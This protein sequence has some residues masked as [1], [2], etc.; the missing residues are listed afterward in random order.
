MR[1]VDLKHAAEAQHPSSLSS[2][3]R[4]S[5][6]SVFSDVKWDFTTEIGDASLCVVD[7]TI[8]WEFKVADGRGSLDPVHG[9]MLLAL[10]Q[11][12]YTLLF[13]TKPR[14]C[15]SVVRMVARLKGFVSFL[16][17]GEHP[18]YR[19]QDVLESD[20][21]RYVDHL[22]LRHDGHGEVHPSTLARQLMTLNKLFDYQHYL[23]DH[24]RYRPTK[25][26][27]P[28][29]VAGCRNRPRVTTEAVPDP[30]LKALIDSA[31][32]YTQNLAPA[33][34]KCLREYMR[35]AQS[36]GVNSIRH[37]NTRAWHIKRFFSGREDF[38]SSAELNS[39]LISLRTACFIVIAFS[40]GMRLSEI[41]ATRRNCVRRQFDPHHGVFY[42][43]H[44]LLFKTQKKNSGSPRSWM[45]GRLA[46]HAVS[47]MTVMGRLLG[48]HKHS[49]YLLISFSH[50]QLVDRSS[51]TR[52][53]ACL[54]AR[55][56]GSDLKDFCEAHRLG[57]NI[58]P[59]Q[60][61]RSFARNIIR[62]S[63]TPLLALKEHFKHWSLY[64]TD[65]YVGL[66][67]EL[68][69]TLEAERLLLSIEAMDKICTQPA[70]G[71]GGRK[72]AY[73]LER[74]IADGRLPRSF[75]GKAGAEFRKKMIADLHDS[76]MI[77]TPCGPFTYCVFQKDSALCTKGD[78]PVAHKCNPYDCRNSYILP[79]NAPFYR[80]KLKVVGN[81]YRGLSDEE[82]GSPRGAFYRQELTQITRV[83]EPF[84]GA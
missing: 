56:A 52:K 40:T 71:A 24:L 34:L 42:W 64:M 49:P 14:K 17:G 55:K 25:E 68:I 36:S 38:R 28:A 15:V 44:S 75:K 7:R 13:L 76:G 33:I 67:Q 37:K 27:T 84:G 3:V 6:L 23:S 43:I 35:F 19:F 8:N 2:D 81:L 77:V 80:D 22:R 65:W 11:L 5:A 70:G 63:T 29:K 83:L 51:P 39:S 16:G 61:R 74:R 30:D 1:L 32:H 78:R 20:L 50:F 59:H 12:A 60:L 53:L 21:E 4:V 48:A 18:I 57:R 10:K 41:M 31:L 54:S 79:E 66:D 82:K 72:W 73:E 9:V 58:H 47:V 46:A 45:C 62:H 69:E 26:T